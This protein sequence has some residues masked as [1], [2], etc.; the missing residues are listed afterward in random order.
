MGDPTSGGRERWG[1]G[2]AGDSTA[3]RGDTG[4]SQQGPLP[5]PFT[6]ARDFKKKRNIFLPG[7]FSQSPQPISSHPAA[8]ATGKEQMGL[9]AKS[10]FEA[11]HSLGDR[12]IPSL[13][14]CHGQAL[15]AP[16]GGLA[17]REGQGYSL[18]KGPEPPEIHLG[19]PGCGKIRISQT[20]GAS[21]C[22]AHPQTRALHNRTG[23]G[24]RIPTPQ[25]SQ[26][27]WIPQTDSSGQTGM[28]RGLGEDKTQPVISLWIKSPRGAVVWGFGAGKQQLSP[29]EIPQDPLEYLR[30]A[31]RPVLGSQGG[32]GV[33]S[34]HLSPPLSSPCLQTELDAACCAQPQNWF[35]FLGR[36]TKCEAALQSLQ[37]CL[38]LHR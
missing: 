22:K 7:F 24:D 19:S 14:P 13:P 2:G 37:S 3:P 31:A 32:E 30:G 17:R 15:V 33:F 38:G 1:A 10:P 34:P 18:P 36:N 27:C 8:M 9:A 5:L 25:L 20:S 21:P 23:T 16:R 4:R 12:D 35:L 29:P 6:S 28:R 26:P 11:N